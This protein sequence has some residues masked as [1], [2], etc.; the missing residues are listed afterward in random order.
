LRPNKTLYAFDAKTGKDL[1]QNTP[2]DWQ[3]QF[4]GSSPV[5]ARIGGESVIIGRR[6]IHRASDGTELCPNHLDMSLA[7]AT[8]IVEDGVIFNPFRFRGWK[9]TTSFISVKLPASTAA[10][11]ESRNLWAPEGKDVSMTMRGPIFAIASPLYVDGIVYAIEMSGGLTAV[12]PAG[13]KSLYRQWLDGYNRY[14]RYLYGV[15]AEPALEEKTSTSPTTRATRT[16]SS[17]VLNSKKS[18]RTF[19]KTFTSRDRAAIP[20][21]RN[22]STPRPISTGR[23]APARGTILV[24]HR[25]AAGRASAA[26]EAVAPR[27]RSQRRDPR[28]TRK[29]WNQCSNTQRPTSNAQRSMKKMALRALREAQARAGSIARTAPNSG[30]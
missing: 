20:A 16:S 12:D 5:V 26:S 4:C 10:G 24:L 28:T 2:T 7:E 27:S 21:D 30:G 3:N 15:A 29:T 23:H 8:P 1:W 6:F 25:G 19:S 11:R 18:G 9:E 14:N 13:R 22:L 17:P